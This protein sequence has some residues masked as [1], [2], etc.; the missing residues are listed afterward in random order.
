MSRI[1]GSHPAG[2]QRKGRKGIGTAVVV[3]LAVLAI[4]AVLFF[5]L[6]DV[7][8]GIQG[9]DVDVDVP[10]VNADVDAPEVDVNPEDEAEEGQDG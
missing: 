9:G 5:W 10:E 6:F 8:A 1:E 7:D 2:Q 4:A 3:L